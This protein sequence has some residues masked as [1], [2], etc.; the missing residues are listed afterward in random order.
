MKVLQLPALNHLVC[1]LLKERKTRMCKVGSQGSPADFPSGF[2]V[3][4]DLI[5]APVEDGRC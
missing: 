4:G 1:S 3:V 2:H 5:M